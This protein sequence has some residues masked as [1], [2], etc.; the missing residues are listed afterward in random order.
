[1]PSGRAL[2]A[3]GVKYESCVPYTGSKNCLQTTSCPAP[4]AGKFSHVQYASVAELQQHIMTHGSVVT[5]FLVCEWPGQGCTSMPPA[6]AWQ[7]PHERISM[8]IALRIASP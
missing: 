4:P 5:S 2:A 7:W 6:P 8:C 1:M 3:A